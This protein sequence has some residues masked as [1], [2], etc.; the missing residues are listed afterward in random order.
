M[1]NKLM[2]IIIFSGIWGLI[3]IIFFMI[4]I[5]ILRNRKKKEINCTSKTYGKVKDIVRQ[6]NYDL[7]NDYSTYSW[8]PIFE[9]NIGELKF[10]KQSSYGSSTTKYVIGQDVEIYYNPDD[11]NDYYIAGESL[12]RTLG[13]IFTIVGVVAIIIAIF[14]A[15]FILFILDLM[16]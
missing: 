15:V 12:P 9:Y 14:V 5:G 11:Y 3:G 10:V 1:D 6:R 13:K 2:F 4:G 7:D 8:Y 16:L